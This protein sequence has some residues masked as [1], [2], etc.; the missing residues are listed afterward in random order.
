MENIDTLIF[1]EA[2]GDEIEHL[3]QVNKHKS[4]DNELKM[5]NTLFKNNQQS[6]N[7]VFADMKD[8][9]LGGLL[10]ILFSQEQVDEWVERFFPATSNSKYMLLGVKTV[11]IVVLFWIIKNWYLCRN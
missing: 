3:P 8:A 5:M 7:V 11:S 4:T 1:D 10:F 6:I 9:F 2:Y